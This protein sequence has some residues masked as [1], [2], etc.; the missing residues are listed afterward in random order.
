VP[1]RLRDLGW[2]LETHDDHFAQLTR[3]VDL[4]PAVAERGWVF[5]TQDARI[6]YRPA[7]AAA[8]RAA[9]LR[10]FVLITGNL[11]WEETVRVLERARVAM[12]RLCAEHTGPFVCRVGKDG[13]LRLL[14]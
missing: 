9:G 13:S 8:L 1:E 4:L 3:D 7:E 14:E 10:T 11:T 12:E 6:R 2:S 5:V